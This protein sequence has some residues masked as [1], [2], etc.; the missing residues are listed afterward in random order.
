MTT[1]LVVTTLGLPLLMG[2][3]LGLPFAMVVA[4]ARPYGIGIV[5]TG[6]ALAIISVLSH[7][8]AI[9]AIREYGPTETVLGFILVIGVFIGIF[10]GTGRSGKRI[11]SGSLS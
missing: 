1:I 6:I 11:K 3:L 2:I 4:S 8:V 5:L 9:V 7:G 10:I